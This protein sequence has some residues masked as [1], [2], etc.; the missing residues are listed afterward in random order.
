VQARQ[1]DDLLAEIRRGVKEK[2]AVAIGADCDGRLA[3]R[4]NAF[5]AVPG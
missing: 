3:A 5:I 2:Q 1:G 4:R